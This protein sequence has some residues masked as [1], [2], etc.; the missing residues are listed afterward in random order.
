MPQQEDQHS[1]GKYKE[2]EN[3]NISGASGCCVTTLVVS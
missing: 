2:E 1:Y 3:A